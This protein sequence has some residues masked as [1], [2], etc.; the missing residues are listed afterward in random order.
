[1]PGAPSWLHSRASPARC[2][3][4]LILGQGIRMSV[5]VACRCCTSPASVTSSRAV[6]KMPT[7]GCPRGSPNVLAAGSSLSAGFATMA[8][9]RTA[10]ASA[11]NL[12][13]NHPKLMKCTV[14]LLFFTIVLASP[15]EAQHN[16]SLTWL[17]SPDAA[18]NPSL[19]YNV[20]RSPG[21]TSTFLKRNASPVSTTTYLDASVAPGS[22]CYQVTSVLSGI[23]GSPS[24]QVAVVIGSPSL[25][26]QMG[27][28]RRGN[29]ITWLRCVRSAS[30]AHP[31]KQP[32][33]P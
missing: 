13:R 9:H 20:Y 29:F 30:E 31:K 11:T 15:A 33:T 27:C 5:S 10:S 24:N 21:C 4:S 17:A 2:I 28:S 25:P 14:A 19:T 1:M 12:N 23:E 18:S 8:G 16:V 7:P 26:Q 6:W 22:Y 32:P 3:C